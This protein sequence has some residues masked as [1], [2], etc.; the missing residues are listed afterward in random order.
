MQWRFGRHEFTWREAPRTLVQA[1]EAPVLMGVLNVTPD[2]FSDGGR[3][4]RLDRALRHGMAMVEAGAA[5]IDV[6]GESSR[7][8]AEP[9]S[10]DEERA[11]VVPVIEALRRH[12]DVCVSIDTVKASVA[13]A[14]LAAGADVIN[15]ITA[16]TGDE[17]MASVAAEAGAGVVLMHMRGRPKTM[18]RGDLSSPDIV[19]EVGGYL[20]ER[21]EAVCAAGVSRDAVCVDPGVGFG[22]T[23]EQNL[24]L[25]RGTPDLCA[26]GYPVLSALSRKSFVGRV[27]EPGSERTAPEDRLPGSL[28]LSVVHLAAGARVFRVHDVGPQRAALAAAWSALESPSGGPPVP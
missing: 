26:T 27:S 22:K 10:A 3:F 9:V 12:T 23:V 2:S 15:D 1:A 19:G 24:A 8:G 6:G 11:R 7:P 20:A 25:V 18:Q 28:A 21:V 14:A 5:I 16:M 13:R 17:A 4:E